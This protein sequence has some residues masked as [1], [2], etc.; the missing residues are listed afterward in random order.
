[1]KTPGSAIVPSNRSHS[2]VCL[3]SLFGTIDDMMAPLNTPLG[4]V[5]WRS[6]P[7]SKILEV[8]IPEYTLTKSYKNLVTR[9]ISVCVSGWSDS[10]RVPGTAGSDQRLPITTD[11]ERIWYASCVIELSAG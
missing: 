8:N 11:N 6:E 5:T 2:A 10:D 9:T 3:M 4:K 1:M 7:S